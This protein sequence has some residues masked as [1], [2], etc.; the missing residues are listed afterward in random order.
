VLSVERGLQIS[1]PS[2]NFNSHKL[3]ESKLKSLH[4]LKFLTDK[5]VHQSGDAKLDE[6]VW[7]D[8]ILGDGANYNQPGV[9]PE[10]YDLFDIDAEIE[11]SQQSIGVK[12]VRDFS[13]S[14][15]ELREPPAKKR[16]SH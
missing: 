14:N 4:C 1:L 2:E 12:R 7:T 16:R 6:L 13:E 9:L 3:D 11:K 15:D 10:D 5:I 8:W